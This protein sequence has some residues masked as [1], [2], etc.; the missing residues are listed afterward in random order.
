MGEYVHQG[1]HGGSP[2]AGTEPR[3]LTKALAVCT[4]TFLLTDHR[5]LMSSSET[6]KN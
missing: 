1:A 5:Q 6:E 2:M 3:V 4:T